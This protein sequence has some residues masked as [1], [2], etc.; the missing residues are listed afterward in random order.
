LK[1]E[2]LYQSLFESLRD[3]VWIA[4]VDG[5]I[6]DANPSTAEMLG[7]TLD[8]II[9]SNVITYYQNPN[10]RSKFIEQVLE[11]GFV[12]DYQINM[13]KN[14]GEIITCLFTATLL[15]DKDSN[16]IGFQG[17]VR[18][19]TNRKK[20]EDKL[21]ESEEKYK[22]LVENVNS[23]IAK[24]DNNGKIIWMN[25]YGINYFGYKK[26]ELIGKRWDETIIP[27]YDS[28]GEKLGDL[29]KRI[30]ESPNKYVRN[31]NENLKK[32][33]ERVWIN[34]TNNPIFDDNG[35]MAY[36]FSVGNDV[37]DYYKLQQELIESE[38]KIR[39]ISNSAQD[40]IITID[41]EGNITYWNKAAKN[42]FHYSLEEVIGKNLHFLL[43]PKKYHN[44]FSK[45]M[46]KFKASGEGNA[47]G[48][49]LE[50]SALRRNGEEFP[51][52]ISLSAVK[53]KD[54]W[55]AIGIIRDISGRKQIEKTLNQRTEAL[56]KSNKELEEFAYIA[57]HDLQEPLRMISSYVQLLQRRYKDK[58]DQ[59]ANDFIEYSV[60]G[61]IRMKALINDLLTYS[62]VG[63]KGKEFAP[64]DINVVLKKVLQNLQISIE[65]NNANITIGP[66][67]TILCDD[68]QMIQLFQ[69]LIGNA[70]KFKGETPPIVSIRYNEEN[71]DFI[72]S[73]SDNGIGIEKEYYDRIFM[74]FQRLHTRD[75]YS[76][77]G[78]GLA[79]CKKIVERHGGRIWLISKI[80]EGTTFYFSI[81]KK[82]VSD[83]GR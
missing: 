22:E 20:M 65:E 70:I 21:K 9:G 19:I 64:T 76:G 8:E 80:G 71:N 39:A 61:S 67:P 2:N 59:D 35:N 16:I 77:T 63:T 75:Q 11:Y 72:F 18:D 41:N 43:A 37:T 56:E 38:E 3:A 27:R 79:V 29:A 17:I 58:L 81:P 24:F 48:K 30:L 28:K 5:I 52:E 10:D 31:I 40:A 12:N 42:I 49:T 55:N 47:I 23:I 68:I 14:N 51:I 1:N 83:G 46:E 36:I 60:E 66:M 54:K 33:G 50:L 7:Y 82:E 26:E 6:L 34:W 15:K 25:D 74:I 13:K 78:I 73:I 69:N 57:S 45:G 53:I 62:R 32:N 4:S 44:D